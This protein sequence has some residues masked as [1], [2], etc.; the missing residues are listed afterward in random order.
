MKL[1]KVF[2]CVSK[3]RERN[4]TSAIKIDKDLCRKLRE[5]LNSR[6]IIPF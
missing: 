4:L 1:E 6:R 5:T 2:G 3:R